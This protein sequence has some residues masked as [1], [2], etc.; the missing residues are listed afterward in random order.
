[1]TNKIHIKNIQ[2]RLGSLGDDFKTHALIRKSSAYVSANEDKP[3]NGEGMEA[4]IDIFC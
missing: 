1:M 3:S 2:F 4:L